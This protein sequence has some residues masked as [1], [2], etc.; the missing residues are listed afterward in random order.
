MDIRLPIL[1]PVRIP[2]KHLGFWGKLKAYFAA[3]RWLVSEDYFLYIPWFN[4]TLFIPKG[5]KF[6]AASIPRLLWP[7]LSPTGILLTGSLFHDFGY[8]YNYLLNDKKEKIFV[9]KGRKFL[10][11]LIKDI[12]IYVNG[13]SFMADTVY[14][15]LRI[16]GWVAWHNWRNK[17]NVA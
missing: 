5:F 3:R 16:S 13:Y 1:E 12:T 4:E 6:D 15:I 11:N 10:D 8:R 9:K 2:T 17:E 7:L 14:Y